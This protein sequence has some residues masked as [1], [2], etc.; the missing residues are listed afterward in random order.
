MNSPHAISRIHADQ[1]GSLTSFKRALA[2]ALIACSLL[3][4]L[5]GPTLSAQQ[6]PAEKG[7]GSVLCRYVPQLC[8]GW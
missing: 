2:A 1:T 3:F 6:G 8:G 4:T 5:G 7:P